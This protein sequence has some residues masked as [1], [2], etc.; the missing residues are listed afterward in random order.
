MSHFIELCSCGN[1]L[2]RCRCM[3]PHETRISSKPCVCSRP[4][5]YAPKQQ[6]NATENKPDAPSSVPKYPHTE[7]IRKIEEAA[8]V[9]AISEEEAMAVTEATMF[10]SLIETA[11]PELRE[12]IKGMEANSVERQNAVMFLQVAVNFSRGL[13]ADVERVMKLQPIRPPAVRRI[14][15]PGLS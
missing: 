1:V 9:R 10:E 14:V 13:A 6:A 5:N 15:G 12:S 11:I 2:A 7:F 4:G 8:A 3:G